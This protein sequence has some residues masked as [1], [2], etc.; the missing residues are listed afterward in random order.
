[1]LKTVAGTATEAE[2][3]RA[4]KLIP[5]NNHPLISITRALKNDD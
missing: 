2:I 4:I 1:L 5:L 3:N